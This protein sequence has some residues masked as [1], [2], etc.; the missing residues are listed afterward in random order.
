MF[1]KKPVSEPSDL[2]GQ[3]IRSSGAQV[4]TDTLEA[5]GANTNV[6]AWSESYQ[7][8]QQKVIDG[9]EVHLSAA[10][11]SSIQEV[12]HY[13]SF[14]GHQQLLTALV[15]S[16]KW[17]QNLPE[18]YQK[19]VT[20]ASYEAG[21]AGSEAVIEKNDEYL[22]TL[23]DGG[24][25]VVDCDVDAFKQACEVVYDELGYTEIKAKLDKELGR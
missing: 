10:V 7:A 1:T 15:I 3:R 22:Q 24:I 20:E 4:V 23:I 19:I 17:F 5:M 11:G 6:L 25:E 2:S 12:T 16:E 13:L 21:V 14:T 18:E 8:L 9:V